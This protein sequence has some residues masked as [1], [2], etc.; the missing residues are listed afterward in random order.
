MGEKF[1]QK[2]DGKLTGIVLRVLGRSL[3]AQST[4]QKRQ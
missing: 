4:K 2:E 3:A 1:K